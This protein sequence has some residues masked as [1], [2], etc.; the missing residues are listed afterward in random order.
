MSNVANPDAEFG[1]M[2]YVSIQ[3]DGGTDYAA[4]GVLRL[5]RRH[6]QSRS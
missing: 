5:L 2:V 1:G 6:E 4:D 3:L